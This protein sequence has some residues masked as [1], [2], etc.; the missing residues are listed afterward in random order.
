MIVTPSVGNRCDLAAP[1]L[2]T[3]LSG[4]A[5]FDAVGEGVSVHG[6]GLAGRN[7]RG[8]GRRHDQGI[9]PPHLFL[10]EPDG[11]VRRIG[12]QGIAAHQFSQQRRFVCR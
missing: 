11:V 5:L 10:E 3:R 8:I 12:T 6:Q 9:Q 1:D 2:Q 4:Q 7:R